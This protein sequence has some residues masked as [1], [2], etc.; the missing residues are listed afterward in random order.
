M[1]PV[2]PKA[3]NPVESVVSAAV[4]LEIVGN[5]VTDGPPVP[6]ALVLIPVLIPGLVIKDA[7]SVPCKTFGRL[8]RVS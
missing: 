6:V 4:V 2:V 1:N 3:V 7:K 5:S 8:A